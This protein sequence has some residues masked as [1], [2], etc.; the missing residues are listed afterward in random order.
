M[1]AQ[2]L[3]DF[4]LYI[5]VYGFAA[6][7]VEAAWYS[8]QN[9][10]F[11]NRGFITLPI[12]L[13][14]GITFAIL[15][16]VLPTLDGHLILQFV[17][18]FIVL[19]VIRSLTNAFTH[20]I[21]GNTVWESTGRGGIPSTAQEWISAA[22][23]DVLY[24]LVYY[25]IHP[26]LAT[27]L[28]IVPRLVIEIIVYTAGVL[29]LLDF[30]AMGL[31]I[32]RG[33]NPEVQ[34]AQKM[35]KTQNLADRISSH[36]WRRLRKA[37]PGIENAQDAEEKYTFAKGIC[38]DKLVWVFLI[39]AFLGDIVET[40][41]CGL[42]NGEWMNRSSVLY[43]PFSFVWGFGAVVLTVSLHRLAEKSD[44]WVFLGGFFIGGAYEYLCSVFTELVFGTV[45]WD[46]SDMP[47]NIGGRT[48]VLFMF[49]W[50]LLALIWVKN[51]YPPMDKLIEKVPPVAGKIATWVVVFAMLC[52][53]LL[54]AAAMIRYNIRA[55]SP[56]PHGIVERFLDDRYDDA[57][58]EHRWPNMIVTD[59]AE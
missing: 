45:F 4:F 58:I 5:L 51:I 35:G 14:A 43:G 21:S 57:F 30:A 54:T 6:W 22:V 25:I 31:A 15:V 40:F 34:A 44:R 16:Q 56:E 36:I 47:L 12:S 27:F 50:G 19:S 8:V 24:L 28:L 53:G 37:Y 39:C 33:E 29:L 13:P 48:N 32:H 42:V 9:R 38:L 11:V 2:S 46:Y 41:Y 3:F 59:K 1:T 52:N 10:R 49:F 23:I 26:V 18:T 7:A 20:R 55:V 17:Y